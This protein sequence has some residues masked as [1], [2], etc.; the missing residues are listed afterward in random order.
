MG[1]PQDHEEDFLAGSPFT[2][3]GNLEGNLM[4]IHGTGDDNVHYQGME[5]L[6]NELI[7][8]NKY[9]DMMSYPNRSHGIY[10]G[11]NT[12]RHVYTTI[13]RYLMEHVEAG[14]QPMGSE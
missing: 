10:E 6:I 4:I 1:L 12:R 3:A 9:F 11:R 7:A 14:G 8:K 13:A 2:H 5:V